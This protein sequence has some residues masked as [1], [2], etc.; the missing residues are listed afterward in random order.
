LDK[1]VLQRKKKFRELIEAGLAPYP[2]DFKVDTNTLKLH[3][4]YKDNLIIYLQVG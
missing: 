2:N 3:N 1:I 4:E